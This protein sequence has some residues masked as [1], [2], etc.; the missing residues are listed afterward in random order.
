MTHPCHPE[1]FLTILHVHCLLEI[2]I[3]WSKSPLTR[4][5]PQMPEAGKGGSGSFY[6]PSRG[7]WSCLP[8]R[9]PL[10]EDFSKEGG[11][12]ILDYP[13]PPIYKSSRGRHAFAWSFTNPCFKATQRLIYPKTTSVLKRNSGISSTFSWGC[14]QVASQEAFVELQIIYLILCLCRIC[15][16][17]LLSRAGGEL[18]HLPFWRKRIPLQ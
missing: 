3:L 6:F 13:R 14:Q 15:T 1:Q 12:C 10:M 17:W 16:C 11:A 8:P 2:Q 18:E 5:G 9:P 7:T 4:P